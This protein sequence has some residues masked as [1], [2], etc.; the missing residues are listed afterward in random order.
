MSAHTAHIAQVREISATQRFFWSIQREIWENRVIYL[1][2]LGV[3]LLFLLGFVISLVYLPQ[4]MRAVAGADPMTQRDTIAMPYNIAGGLAMLITMLVS[5]FY[6][7]DALY[8]ERR[9]RSVLFW[10]SMP[11]S[12]KVTVLAKAAVAIVLIPLLGTAIVFVTELIM[13]SLNI[14]VLAVTG[15][16]IQMVWHHLSFFRMS[17]LLLYHIVT[18]HILWYAP[19]YA[20]LLLISAWARRA[21]LLWALLP[22]IAVSYLEKIAFN[23]THVWSWLGYRLGGGME[24]V[25]AGGLPM[26]PMTHITFGRF[27]TNPGLWTGLAFTAICLYLAMRLRRYRDVA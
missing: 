26:N 16:D 20:W 18:G 7:L 27:I 8:G 6:A 2:P 15:P 19:L 23:T 24:A 5:I 9:D 13:L 3:C 21:P 1:A 12:D 22:P 4:H 25:Y 11:V 17:Y 14:A 10:K